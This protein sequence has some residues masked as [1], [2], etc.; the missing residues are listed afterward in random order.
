ME[1][2]LGSRFVTVTLM[3]TLSCLQPLLDLLDKLCH[4]KDYLSLSHDLVTDLPPTN[5]GTTLPPLKKLKWRHTDTGVVAVVVRK[6]SH[7]K[8]GVPTLP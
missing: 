5:W 4:L 2:E 6:L 1:F 3:P 8:V 7:W